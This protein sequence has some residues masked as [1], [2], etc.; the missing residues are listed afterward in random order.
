MSQHRMLDGHNEDD[1]ARNAFERLENAYL[2]ELR[3]RL[4]ARGQAVLDDMIDHYHTE[5]DRLNSY[6]LQVCNKIN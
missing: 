6:I 5:L 3:K 2:C 1:G 4:D